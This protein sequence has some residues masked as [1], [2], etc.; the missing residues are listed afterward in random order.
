[1]WIAPLEFWCHLLLGQICT[2]HID[3]YVQERCNSIANAHRTRHLL[4]AH[5]SPYIH[6]G[7]VIM[8]MIASQ[9]TSLTIV[10]STVYSDA[11]QRKHQSYASLAFV[12]GNHCGPVNSPQKW[13]VTPKMFPFDYVIMLYDIFTHLQVSICLY[14]VSGMYWCFKAAKYN[15]SNNNQTSSDVKMTSILFRLKCI[16]MGP[17]FNDTFL[18]I[19]LILLTRKYLC[20]DLW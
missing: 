5:D 12:R 9:I 3:G 6:Y 18:V 11:D 2:Q 10:Y 7:E 17:W 16:E 20:S 14:S 19:I 13:P 1:M 8:G 15:F 4:V